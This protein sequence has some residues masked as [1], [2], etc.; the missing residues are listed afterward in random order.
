M[1]KL[2]RVMNQMA[3][4]FVG[5][6][7]EV[8]QR[9]DPY[10]L[11]TIIKTELRNYGVNLDCNYGVLNGNTKTLLFSKSAVSPE[12]LLL[13]PYKTLLFPNDVF[14]KAGLPDS[15]FSRKHQI[16]SGFHVADD[17]RSTIFTLI[18]LFGF[19][20]TIQSHSPSEKTFGYQE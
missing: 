4:E 15:S 16:C 20:Y 14:S 3:V 19:A 8:T 12:V 13:S 1:E 11:D 10:Q 5:K 6:E 7:S 17:G 9:I 2:Q 18:I